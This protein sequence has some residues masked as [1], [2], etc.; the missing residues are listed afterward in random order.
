MA[1]ERETVTVRELRNNG[2][3]VLSRVER[4]EEL[5]VTRDGEPVAR[6]VPLPRKP[7]SARELLDRARTLPPVDHDALRAD[8][9]AVIDPAL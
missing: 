8:L 4:G 9:D 3:E 2:A 6:L 1:S 7:L 5:I